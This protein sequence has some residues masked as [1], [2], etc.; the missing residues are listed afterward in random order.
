MKSKSVCA[1]LLAGG[2]GTR[3]SDVL[4]DRPKPMALIAGKPFL[5]WVIAYLKKQG[6][7]RYIISLG[8]L[9]R[10]AQA[11]FDQREDDGVQIDTVVESFPLGTGGGFLFAAN[12]FEKADVYLASNADSL[13]LADLTPAWALLE[14]NDVDGVI[15]GRQMEDASRY[16][17]LSFNE[18]GRL[19]AFSEKKEGSGI[20]NGGI[21]LFKS[22][23]LS[24][25][26]TETPMS[27]EIDGFPVLLN[28]D[29]RIYVVSSD[30]PF[31]DIGTP[32]TYNA[33]ERFINTYFKE[34]LSC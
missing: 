14:R 29:T 30:A 24:L 27:M 23:V 33:A 21:Y 34:Q 6:I 31:I 9:A 3:L 8:H 25:L 11:Y 1:V 2:K 12:A 19:I 26:P 32:E 16:G 10:V 20:I 7:G 28:S 18:S 15:I 5:E 17:T 13:L 22:S 4:T